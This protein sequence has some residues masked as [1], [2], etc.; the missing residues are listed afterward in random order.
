VAFPVIGTLAYW[1]AILGGQFGPG[2]A[3]SLTMVPPLLAVLW[4][5]FHLLD[6]PARG[7]M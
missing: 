5:L 7:G 1:M 4:G 6:R 2:A 3:L